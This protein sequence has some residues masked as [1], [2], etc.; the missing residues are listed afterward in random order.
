MKKFLKELIGNYYKKNL[1][2]PDPFFSLQLLKENGFRPKNIFD[3]GAYNGDFAKM[4]AS[5]WSESEIVCFEGLPDKVK[6]LNQTIASNKIKIIEGL[7]GDRNEKDVKFFKVESATSVLEE[8]TSNDF[9]VGFQKMHTLDNCLKEFSLKA[10]EF[11]KIDTQGY[12]YNILKG[13]ENNIKHTEVVLAELNFI[14][15]H[16]NVKLAYDVISFLHDHHF[17]IYDICQ[18]HRRPSDKAL[19]QSDFIFCKEDSLLRQ[20]KTW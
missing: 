20:S 7:V 10:P 5:I 16:K 15:I 17:V 9:D 2:I 1:K 14:D 13:Y 18:L 3:V 12:E 19:W 8:N 11:L 6:L 4:V